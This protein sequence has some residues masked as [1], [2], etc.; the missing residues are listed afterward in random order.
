MNAASA[1][2][3]HHPFGI[4]VVVSSGRLTAA[5][6]RAAEILGDPG[7]GRRSPAPRCCEL[8]R[9][10]TPD[11]PPEGR[12]LTDIALEVGHGL[13]EVRIDIGPDADSAVWVTAAPAPRGVVFSL[14]R[15]T[16]GDRRRRTEPHWLVGPTLRIHTLGATHVASGDLS[17][18]GSWIEHRTGK[19]LKYLITERRSSV[20]AEQIAAALWP[21]GGPEVLG[22]LRQCV[23]GLREKLEPQ[24]TKHDPSSFVVAR[25]GGYGLDVAR[26][27]IDAD[28]FE[29]SARSG[30]AAFEAQD[31]RAALR[32]LDAA[33]ELYRGDF[34][35]DDT[36]AEWAFAERDRLRDL[37][38]QVLRTVSEIH[39]A[40]GAVERATEHLQRLTQVDP[41]DVD[42]HRQL[43]G[44]YLST[45]RRSQA[46]RRYDRL[47]QQMH[48]AFGEE[49]DFE[50]KDL[51]RGP[52]LGAAAR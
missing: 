28:E 2:F 36:Y 9:C 13:P 37:A 42:V 34:L 31:S 1:A 4:L 18:D 32:H 29:A 14:R 5:N 20:H 30:L 48:K 6:D 7:L 40:S 52:R 46:V 11:G 49:L 12:C 24:R 33:L 41:F 50:L 44:L 21:N 39:L 45:G 25:N 27:W 19:L 35:G 8:L 3:E 47:R 43:I 10:G 16:R 23:H 15:G 22:A 26:V 38:G 17:L 51:S